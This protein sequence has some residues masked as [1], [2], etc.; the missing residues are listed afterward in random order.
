VTTNPLVDME[1]VI[2]VH[3]K[4]EMVA[5]FASV[6]DDSDGEIARLKYLFFDY[7]GWFDAVPDKNFIRLF[8][9][10]RKAPQ[11]SLIS[12]LLRLAA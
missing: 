12:T 5:Q 8:P 11:N 6:I 1:N 9:I 2:K 7:D 4:E 3:I 10:P